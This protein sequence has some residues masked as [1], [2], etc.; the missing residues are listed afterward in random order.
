MQVHDT[1]IPPP[2]VNPRPAVRTHNAVPDEPVHGDITEK[3]REYFQ[4]LF[5]GSARELR[6]HE[7]YSRDGDSARPPLGGIVDRKG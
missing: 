5:P 3:E 6:A 4:Q 7:V 1:R 2:A